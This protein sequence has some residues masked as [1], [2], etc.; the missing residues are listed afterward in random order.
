MSQ[1]VLYIAPIDPVQHARLRRTFSGHPPLDLPATTLDRHA[2]FLGDRQVAFLF[3]GDDPDTAVRAL[4]SDHD[5]QLEVMELVGAV[6]A[7]EALT[8]VLDWRR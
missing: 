4:A 8:P 2:V 1:S 7:P 5:L 6:R 3:E